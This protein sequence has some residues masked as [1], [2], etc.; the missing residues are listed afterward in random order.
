MLITDDGKP[1]PVAI[2][3]R[4]NGSVDLDRRSVRLHD[5]AGDADT[6][7][8]ALIDVYELR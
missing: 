2:C 3:A 5:H 4:V 1:K 7:G 6:T 8:S